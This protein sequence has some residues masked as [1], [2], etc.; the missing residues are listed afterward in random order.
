MIISDP[1]RSL[2]LGDIL[3]IVCKDIRLRHDMIGSIGWAF[4][5]AL[6]AIL[7]CKRLETL[8]TC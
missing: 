4:G 7:E 5:Q 1:R 6:Y 8:E 3:L 2:E